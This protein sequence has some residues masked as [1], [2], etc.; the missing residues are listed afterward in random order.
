M[1]IGTSEYKFRNEYSDVVSLKNVYEKKSWRKGD[2]KLL[3]F[4]YNL[5]K[6]S[7]KFLYFI[8]HIDG[9]V[10]ISSLL[11]L[12]SIIEKILNYFFHY[13]PNYFMQTRQLLKIIV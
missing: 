7:N 11:Y 1:K 4:N 13:L 5:W 9:N 2:L 10:C 6:K 3:R 12:Y 8:F